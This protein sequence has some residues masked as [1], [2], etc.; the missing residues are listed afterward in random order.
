MKITAREALD[1]GIWG[2]IS[3]IGGYSVWAVN[4]G[5]S[6][7]TEIEITIEQFKELTGSY[8]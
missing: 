2:E 8:N 3:E 5:M 4:E 1:L 6:D 7:D